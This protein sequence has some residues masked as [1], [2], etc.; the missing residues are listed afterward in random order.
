MGNNLI[1]RFA[2]LALAFWTGAAANTQVY[3]ADESPVTVLELFTSQGC[4]S[5][6][7]A[8]ALLG[9]F[10]KQDG[11]L[12]LSMPV[13]YWD[14]LGWKDTLAADSFSNRQRFY[15]ENRRDHEIYTPQIVVNGLLHVVGSRQAAIDEAIERTGRVLKPA[16]VA[17]KISSEG[18]S[19]LVRAGVAPETGKYRSGTLWLALFSRTVKV[20]IRRGENFGRKIVYTNV[21]RNLVPA[22]R[23]EGEAVSYRITPP[24]TPGTD[25]CA[26]FL[27]ADSSNAIIGAA[28]LPAQMR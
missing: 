3:A 12:A 25:G 18:D 19:I 13:N 23:W 6:P 14:H 16:R 4:S 5:C 22:G 11:V 17:V 21:V 24:Q 28:V 26:A 8:D 10:A 2:L 1:S 27:Q 15:A 9:K 20:D 7:P